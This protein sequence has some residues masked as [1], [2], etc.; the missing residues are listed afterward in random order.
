MEYYSSHISN[1][2][3]QLSRLPGI[4][5]KSAQRLAFHIMNLSKE[6]VNLL[7]SSMTQAREKIQYCKSCFTLTDEEFCPI[8]RNLRRD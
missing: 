4:G 3:E 1:L 5:V 2:I 6:E 7:A 8:C